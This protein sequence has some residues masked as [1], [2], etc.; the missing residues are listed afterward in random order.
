[1]F[2]GRHQLERRYPAGTGRGHRRNC[3][4]QRLNSRGRRQ[5]DV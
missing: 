2:I 5:D 4:R 3:L 1:M